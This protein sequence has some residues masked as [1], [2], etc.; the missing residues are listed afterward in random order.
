MQLI[1]LSKYIKNG[2]NSVLLNQIPAGK[3]G[4]NIASSYW[5]Q[6]KSKNDKRNL[7]IIINYDKN[8][9]S[10]NE[11]LNC[12]VKVYNHT[13]S[14]LKMP[15]IKLAIPAG[16]EVDLMSFDLLTQS[17]KIAKYENKKTYIVIYLYELKANKCF[18]FSYSLKAKYPQNITIQPSEVYEY[19]NPANN[20]KSEIIKIKVKE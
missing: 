6:D 1:D 19:Y 14:K 20:A 17:A 8:I 3:I 15:I 9:I 7:S 16:F 13:Y 18:D 4:F 5:T 10:Q 11:R 2:E 12:T